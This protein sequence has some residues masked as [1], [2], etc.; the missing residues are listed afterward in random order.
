[1]SEPVTHSELQ[2]L[3]GAFAVDAVD[4]DERELIDR[5]LRECPRCR[6]E[7]ATHRETAA[8]LAQ[9]GADA[10]DAVW[11]RIVSTLDE[12]P[13]PLRLVSGERVQQRPRVVS[14]RTFA[15]L[16]AVA[17]LVI[18]VLGVAT[19]R[20]NRRLDRIQNALH[21]DSLPRAALSALA[22]PS[23][24][25]VDLQ[26]SD[27]VTA[28][29]VVMLRDGT[30]YLVPQRLTPLGADRSYQLWALQGGARISAGVLGNSPTIAA[31]RVSPN[32]NGFA[33]TD[34]VAGGVS[35]SS[36]APIVIGFIRSA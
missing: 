16:V 25:H 8:L 32:V 15:S 7:V 2:E 3:L 33:I 24:V 6:A 23:A 35:T 27:H 29:Q 18:G 5:H 34:E 28:A 17:A 36:R 30:G 10:P 31:F 21:G 9:A 13:P 20:Q 12:A 4:D 26:S 14:M 22:D 1:M 19:T 11:D